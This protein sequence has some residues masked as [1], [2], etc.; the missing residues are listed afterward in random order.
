M[1]SNIFSS[2]PSI[3]LISIDNFLIIE[4]YELITRFKCSLNFIG[5]LTKDFKDCIAILNIF[6]F[7]KLSLF[8][9]STIQLFN[10]ASLFNSNSFF[11]TNLF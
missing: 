1:I 8:S 11:Q 7:L 5:L 10:L 6:S 2:S 4:L 9:I 3:N